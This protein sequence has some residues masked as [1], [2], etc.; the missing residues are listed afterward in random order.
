MS[1]AGPLAP[2]P[3]VGKG[4]MLP[5]P[6]RPKRKREKIVLDEDEWT[7]QL[8]AIIQRDYFPDL[9]KLESQLEWLEVI[10]CNRHSRARSLHDTKMHLG[11][12]AAKTPACQSSY[13]PADQLSYSSLACQFDVSCLFSPGSKEQGSCH[14]PASTGKHSTAASRA[15][16]PHGPDPRI[17]CHASHGYADPRPSSTLSCPALRCS[18]KV[19]IFAAKT[20]AIFICWCQQL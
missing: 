8:E 16:D 19:A 3:P 7:D 13:T 14:N 2:L 9:P 10:V 11:V 17:F 12:G 5:P 20:Q 4:L 18:C 15:E 1:E 6:S